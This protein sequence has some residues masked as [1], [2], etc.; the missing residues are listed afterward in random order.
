LADV[1]AR[2]RPDM[3]IR[4]VGTG[5][6]AADSIESVGRKWGRATARLLGEARRRPNMELLAFKSSEEIV[7]LMLQSLAMLVLSRYE[8]FGI[9]AAEAMAA[10]LP[11]VAA[12]W[13]ALPEVVGDGGIIT[14]ASN[15]ESV[16]DIVLQLAG[17]PA[18]RAHYGRLGRRR[19]G[20][21]RWEV[22]AERLTDEL[23]AHSPGTGGAK[24][25]L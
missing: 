25:E 12:N 17:D 19:A 11:V 6:T 24:A 10:G 2:R 7:K 23:K 20:Q 13:A 18:L 8:T 21:F 22:C 14:D 1:L 15:P 16:A 5:F 3:K 9:P 4:V